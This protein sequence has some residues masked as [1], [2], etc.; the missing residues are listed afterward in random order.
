MILPSTSG[1]N[2]KQ[3]LPLPGRGRRGEGQRREP[4]GWRD[5]RPRV[6][7]EGTDGQLALLS[8]SSPTQGFAAVGTFLKNAGADSSQ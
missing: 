1:E 8:R 2:D 4:D 3:R 7:A 6:A 5:A